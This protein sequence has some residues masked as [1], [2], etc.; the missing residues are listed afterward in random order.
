MHTVSESY[1]SVP[2]ESNY[3]SLH[4]NEDDKESKSGNV[5][6]RAQP[7]HSDRNDEFQTDSNMY[8]HLHEKP[9]QLSADV[10]DK[11]EGI[12]MSC[13]STNQNNTKL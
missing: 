4:Q 8:N 7:N 6:D 5:Y 2:V 10:Y 12:P 9:V 3:N 1:Y 11:S 13:F